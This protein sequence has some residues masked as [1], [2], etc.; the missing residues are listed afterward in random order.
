MTLD[1]NSC[2]VVDCPQQPPPS[3]RRLEV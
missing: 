2:V 3:G 1:V